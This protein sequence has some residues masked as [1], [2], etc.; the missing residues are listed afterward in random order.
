[1]KR[2]F[3]RGFFFCA[4]PRVWERTDLRTFDVCTIEDV[5]RNMD[6]PNKQTDDGASIRVGPKRSGAPS[7]VALVITR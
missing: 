2:V 5:E 1:M 3:E 7:R 6:D 4:S